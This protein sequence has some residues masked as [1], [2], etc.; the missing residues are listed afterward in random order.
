M[1]K[2]SQTYA[3]L[4]LQIFSTSS[5]WNSWTVN[6][7]SYNYQWLLG[8]T[9]HFAEHYEEVVTDPNFLGYMKALWQD[10][11]TQKN[12]VFPSPVLTMICSV[13]FIK[14]PSCHFLM[15]RHLPNHWRHPHPLW[16]RK[17][18]YGLP[19]VFQYKYSLLFKSKPRI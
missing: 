2:G 14:S 17:N 16:K 10:S 19:W 13:T 18:E 9:V 1:S 8:S 11:Y 3:P 5:P 4:L 7:G 12:P 6:Q 15:T